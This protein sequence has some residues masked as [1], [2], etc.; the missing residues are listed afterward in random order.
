LVTIDLQIEGPA[1]LKLARRSIEAAV[2]GK[3]FLPPSHEWLQTPAAT[4]V[5]LMHD[6]ELRGCIGSIEP[7]RPLGED[8]VNNARGA[9][10]YDPRFSPLTK[11]ELEEID[12]EVSLLSLPQPLEF[13]TDDS[14]YEQLRPGIDGLIFH[15]EGR[16]S[17]FLPQVWEQLREPV[18]FVEELKRKAGVPPQTP[19]QRCSFARYT[20]RKWR[21]GDLQEV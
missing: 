16:R 1:L 17:T 4:F 6:G 20:V 19:I 8:I 21:E 3:H 10:L 7:L 13:Q 9:A 5:T 11:D 2:H 18:R 14:L 12:I 15:C